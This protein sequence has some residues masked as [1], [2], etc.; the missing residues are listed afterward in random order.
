MLFRSI[1][2][3]FIKLSQQDLEL[4]PLPVPEGLGECVNAG[5]LDWCVKG[6]GSLS[7][8]D[9]QSD[10]ANQTEDELKDGEQDQTGQTKTEDK[11]DTSGITDENIF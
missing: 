3:E 6:S 5:I 1:F 4:A 11:I 2:A 10:S 7:D 8:D 9:S